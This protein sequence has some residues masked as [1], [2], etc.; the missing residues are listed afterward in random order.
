V[1]LTIERAFEPSNRCSRYN[2]PVFCNA[3][4]PRPVAPESFFQTGSGKRANRQISV[5]SFAKAPVFGLFAPIRGRQTAV[6][7]FAA[8]NGVDDART[9][10]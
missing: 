8:W 3:A 2:N 1:P 9:A 5:A 10:A 6:H 7:F 4:A